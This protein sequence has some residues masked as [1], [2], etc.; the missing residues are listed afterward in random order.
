VFFYLPSQSTAIQV[1]YDLSD[2][3][4]VQRETQALQKLSTVV[5]LE[6]MLIITR[7]EERTFTLSSGQTIEAI[8][9]WKWLID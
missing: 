3:I 2:A 6:R 5:P 8:P 7:D 1:C 4:T 9:V